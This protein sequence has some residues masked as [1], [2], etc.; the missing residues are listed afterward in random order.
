VT[1]QYGG[2]VS[3]NVTFLA[4]SQTLGS[5]SLS[6]NVASLTTSFAI[7]GMYSISARYGGDSNTIGSTSARLSEKIL[8]AT[9]TT[10]TSSLNPAFHGQGITFTATVTAS[11]GMPP[12]GETVTFYNGSTVLAT[13]ALSAGVASWTTSSLPAGIYNVTAGYPGDA[14]FGASTSASLRQV[15]NSTTR[16]ATT[17][18]LTSSLNPSLYGQR[19]TFTARVTTSGP[20]PPTGTVAFRWTLFGRTYTI[21]SATLSSGGIATITRSDLNADPYPLVAVYRGDANNLASTSVILNQT[22]I[23][24]TSRTG[25]TSSSNPSTLG[26]PVTF[27]ANVT[28]PTVVAKGLVTF[29]LGTLLLGTAQLTNGKAIFT[30]ST[31]PAGSDVVRVTYAGDSNITTSSAAL[32]QVVQP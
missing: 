5:A 26:E 10:L 20:L 13:A 14:N 16:S 28:S 7:A 32:T 19:V 21:G 27:T 2:A 8:A 25:L 3:G 29:K 4:G 30:T 18:I 24:T 6:R 22:V 23:Q 9:A 1:G 11:S 17:T 15:V 12:N 31:L